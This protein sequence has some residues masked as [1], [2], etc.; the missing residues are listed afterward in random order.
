VRKEIQSIDSGL[1]VYEMMSLEE[2][3][4]QRRWAYRVFGTGF[5]VF[6]II[7][8]VL[9]S[10]GLYGMMAYAVT[11][12]TPEIGV[13]LALGATQGRILA[14]ILGQ[15][16]RQLATGLVM[17]LAAAFGLAR[18][19]K[20]LLFQVT[21]TDPVTFAAV[22]GLLAAVGFLACWLPARAAMKVEPTVAL[23][24]E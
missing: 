17:G 1:P 21:A 20:I 14:L 2:N 4:D 15:G 22:A 6:A 24:Y 18:V 16:T 13:R 19:L 7:A 9:S 23:R 12:R 3:L 10:V 5:A 8:V 11:R